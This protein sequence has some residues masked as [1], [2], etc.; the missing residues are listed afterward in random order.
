MKRLLHLKASPRADGSHSLAAAHKFLETLHSRSGAIDVAEVDVWKTDL[1]HLDGALLAAKYAM[2][3][4]GALKADEALAW[5][6][7]QTMV[8]E[9]DAA[10]VVLISTPMWNLSIPYRLK[11]YIDLVTQPGLS[12]RFHPETGYV[13][14]LR[15]RPVVA[16]LASA[17][18]FSEGPSWGRPDLATPYLQEA[19]KFIGLRDVEI[20]PICLTAG[21]PEAATAAAAR[22]QE[23]LEQ[24]ANRL[25]ENAA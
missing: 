5:S 8:Q 18:D 4:G 24:L 19:L 22:A 1:P 13:P 9:L 11:H 3:S 21:K 15:P 20:V 7:I 17:G 2:L 6:A 10:D 23:A 12:F 25:A 16:I 14:L